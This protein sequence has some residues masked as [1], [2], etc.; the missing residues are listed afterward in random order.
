MAR[1]IPW[2]LSSHL[3]S[4]IPFRRRSGLP[5]EDPMEAVRRAF[6]GE[7]FAIRAVSRAFGRPD[8]PAERGRQQ[9]AENRAPI[10][11]RRPDGAPVAPEKPVDLREPGSSSQQVASTSGTP[12]PP[13]SENR[14]NSEA[15]KNNGGAQPTPAAAGNEAASGWTRRYAVG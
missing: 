14:V 15:A 2:P 7:H 3:L 13:A 12:I 4:F 8:P 1:A 9:D 11:E 10:V 6:P 5:V